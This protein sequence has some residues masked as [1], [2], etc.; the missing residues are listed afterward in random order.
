MANASEPWNI[1]D[2]E[3]IPDFPVQFLAEKKDFSPSKRDPDTLARNWPIPGTPSLEHRI[4]GIEKSYVTGDIS[5]DAD[6]HQKMTEVRK[7]KID[8]IAKDVPAQEITRGDTEGDLAVI[9]WGSTFGPIT[10]AVQKTMADGCKVSHIHIRHIWP[11]PENLEALLL[12][13]KKIIVAE[14]NT[15]QLITLIRSRYLIDAQGLNKISGQPFKVS[16]IED[17]IRSTLES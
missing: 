1:P 8:G 12:K 5:Y 17:A 10:R 6:N 15:G 14:M 2:V 13:F 11:L 3:A 7:N 4:G 16:E 9:G